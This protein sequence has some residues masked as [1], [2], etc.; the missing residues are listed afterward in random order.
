MLTCCIGVNVF[1]IRTLN[2]PIFGIIE[3]II[4]NFLFFFLQSPAGKDMLATQ[5]NLED[6]RIK[7]N[8]SAPFLC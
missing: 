3:W 1:N 2:I 7:T 4:V 5:G 6:V 8:K